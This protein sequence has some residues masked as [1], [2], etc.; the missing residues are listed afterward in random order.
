MPAI[1]DSAPDCITHASG[2]VKGDDADFILQ[3]T[4]AKCQGI[5]TFGHGTVYGD[6]GSS[7]S[8]SYYIL[9]WIGIAVMV[10]V[11]VAWV[12]ME[13]RRLLGHA[14]RLRL[15]GRGAGP[16]TLGP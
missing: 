8:T 2:A 14:A 10:A 6:G 12:V 4:Y 13:D 5:M 7:A 15:A 1:I 9:T 3:A 11:I 16:G